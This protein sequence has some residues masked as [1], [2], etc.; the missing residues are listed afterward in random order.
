MKAPGKFRYALALLFVLLATNFLMAQK[1]REGSAPDGMKNVPNGDGSVVKLPDDGTGNAAPTGQTV[2]TGNGINYNGGP[3]LSG[4]PVPIYIIWYGNWNGTG[5][6]T[7]ATQSLIQGFLSSTSLG[8]SSYEAINT[9]YG[10]TTANVT[11]HLNFI[12]ATTDTGSQGTKLRNSRISAAISSALTSGRLP[13]DPNGVY[14]FLSSSNVTE[15]GFCTQF[16]GF[17]THQTLNGADIKWA[18]I[19][20]VDQCPSGCEIQSTGPNSPATGV[21]GA[22]GMANVIT[23]ETEETITDPDLN[24]WFDSAGNEDADKCNFKF[25]PTQTAPNGSKFNQTFGGHN[26]MI[27]M[28]WENS[29]GGGCDQ[30]LGGAFFTN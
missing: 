16:C 17:H 18:F 19:G 12:Q 1:V 24:A 13:T 8:G 3:V 11:G 7:P 26:W 22:D 9:T 15:Q 27:Q 5:S 4:N 20:N 6:N 30:T 28:E 25:G 21:G 10:S 14:L 29:R 2:V 23:H